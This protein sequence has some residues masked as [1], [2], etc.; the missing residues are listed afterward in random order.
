[1]E[2]GKMS[3]RAVK[4]QPK[5]FVFR[6]H[7]TVG[8][9]DAVD[10]KKFLLES[11]VDNGELDILC[12]N[13]RPECIIVG[14]TG[15]GKTA[16][17]ERLN[18]LEE[19]VI[20]I[21]PEGLAL[22][23]VSN[24]DVLNF[25][26]VAGV[27]MDLFYRLLWRHVFAVELIKTRFNIVNERTRDSFLIQIRDRI[28][29]KKARQD[30]LQYLIKW[31][32]SFWKETDYRVKEVTSKL[33]QDLGASLG[34]TVKGSIPA[35]GGVEVSLNAEMAEKLSEEKRAEVVRHGQPVVDKVQIG[36][37]SEV[38][39][40]LDSD[41][42]DDKRKK[43]FITIDRLDENW[44]NDELR[45]QLIRALL[46]TIRDFNTKIQNVKIIVAIR[47]DLIDRVFRYTRSPGYQEEK[48][49]S[50]Y[51]T[52]RWEAD[53]LEELLDRRINQLVR[54]QYTTRNVQ[55]QDMLPSRIQKKGSVKYLLERTMLTP[56]DAIMFFNECIKAAVG[57]PK[58]SP[59]M[60]FEAEGRYSVNRLRA[61]A[62]EWS[63]DYPNLAELVF[64]L[65]GYPTHFRMRN[66]QHR[67]EDC[68][69][70]F[71]FTDRE[72][73]H[74]YCLITEKFNA[75]D[76]DG[77]MQEMFKILFRVGV[78]GVKPESSQSTSWSYMGHK[79]V[80]S[81]SSED[82]PIYIHPAFWN[83]LGIQPKPSIN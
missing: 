18:S 16:L 26:R 21:A 35:L 60:M 13:T 46:E 30:A 54:E 33:E 59:E 31:G 61:L 77:F 50:M 42:L 74:I 37:L 45:Y 12:D 81:Y 64:F 39:K 23:Y 36:L 51:L 55:V 22:T 10:D 72:R 32:E 6:K 15:S 44:V 70:Q 28:L 52:L 27:N 41:I 62:D 3:K 75:D 47:E 8:A 65:K 40:L 63:A 38:I 14:R 11:F 69:L 4:K 17:L 49:K 82:T 1:M 57:K 53:E 80:G 5:S 43:Y 19:R 71:L 58:I 67:I 56:R 24:N 66:V 2:G 73:D 78:V 79:L 48:Y 83:V 29:G 20:K 34:D 9:A 76:I 68:M 7:T 25:F